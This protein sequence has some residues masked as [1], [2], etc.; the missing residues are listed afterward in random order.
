LDRAWSAHRDW[1]IT[2]PAILGE[3][4]SGNNGMLPNPA[5]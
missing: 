1:Q 5:R 3:R 4:E 2:G